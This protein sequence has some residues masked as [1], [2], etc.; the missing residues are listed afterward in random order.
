MEDLR[1][2]GVQVLPLVLRRNVSF[3]IQS[4]Q[5]NTRCFLDQD[6]PSSHFF[7]PSSAQRLKHVRRVESAHVSSSLGAKT[8]KMLSIP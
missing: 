3:T 1:N 5:F 8:S 6:L 2:N 7:T 4:N